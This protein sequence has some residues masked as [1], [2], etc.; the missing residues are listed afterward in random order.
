MILQELTKYYDRLPNA[1]PEGFEKRGI[2]FLV[3]LGREGTFKALEDT[4]TPDGKWMVA[5]PFT[6]PKDETRTSGDAPHLLWGSPEYIFG[7]PKSEPGSSP[8]DLSKRADRRHLKF[9][10]RVRGILPKSVADEGVAAVLRF[11]EA[12]D[13]TAVFRDLRWTEVERSG[14]NLA[15]KLDSVLGLVCERPA[16][17]RAHAEEVA[18]SG[19]ENMQQCLVTGI[20]GAVARKHTAITGVK[21]AKRSGGFIVSFN[22]SAFTSQGKRQGYNAPVGRKA[23]HAYTT[24]LKMLLTRGSGQNVLIGDA[25]AVFWAEKSHP[26]ETYFSDFFGVLPK[27]VSLQDTEA[28]RALYRAPETGA[29]PLFE[30]ETLFYVLGLAPNPNTPRLAVRF[31]HAGTVANVAQ[32]I[33]QHFDDCSIVHR[34][35]E[36]E[37]L[38]LA[39][40]LRSTA[41]DGN[42]SVYSRISQET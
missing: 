41:L 13:F 28:I 36:P 10:D 8:S 34:D 12:G 19:L 7:R 22:Q 32:S 30:D 33:K 16:V 40:L 29:I 11:L 2:P 18:R 5:R 21:G 42:D 17:V 37:H 35:T 1:A 31:W 3:V 15:F 26:M 27:G 4:R 23:E 25:T 20:V 24:A 9:V 39:T 6:V 38:T 14:A